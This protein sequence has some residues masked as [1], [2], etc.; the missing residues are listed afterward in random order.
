[1]AHASVHQF[2]IMTHDLDFSAI[3]AASGASIPSV[4]QIRSANVAPDH[5][6]V[7]ILALLLEH[8]AL[9]NS[10]A[11]ITVDTDRNRVRLLPLLR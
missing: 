11:L 8:E 7:R 1:M 3:L 9:L 4:V 6:G 5:W 10:G 2:V